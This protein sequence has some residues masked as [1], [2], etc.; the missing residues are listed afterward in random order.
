MP[1]T[2]PATRAP[3]P[4]PNPSTE[5]TG[6]MTGATRLSF[7]NRTCTTTLRRQT[8]NTSRGLMR[9][10]AKVMS[11]LL[12]FLQKGIGAIQL[13]R[14]IHRRLRAPAYGLHRNNRIVWHSLQIL[15]GPKPGTKDPAAPEC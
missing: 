12:P 7:H 9:V 3:M 11:Y 4:H 14:L 15:P 5:M 1:V 8:A 6:S 2:L 10:A 13:A